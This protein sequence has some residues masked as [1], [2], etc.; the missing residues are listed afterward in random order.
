[1]WSA[2]YMTGVL[3]SLVG[4]VYFSISARR[5]ELHPLAARMTLGKMNMSLGILLLLFGINQY[6]FEPLTTVRVIVGLLFLLV[7]LFNFI[8]GT[9]NFLTN[10]REWNAFQNKES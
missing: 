10:R 6:T 8:Q 1:M 4:S 9:R 5:R 7:G 3:A 2:F